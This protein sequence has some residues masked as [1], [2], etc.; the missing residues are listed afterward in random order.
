MCYVERTEA[1]SFKIL[2]N[3]VSS[4]VK[5]TEGKFGDNPNFR[6]CLCDN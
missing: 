1:N 6:E 5:F 2:M 4:E 3:F